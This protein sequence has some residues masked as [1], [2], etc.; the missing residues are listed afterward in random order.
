MINACII[1][2]ISF[3][4]IVDITFQADKKAMIAILLNDIDL[5]NVFF[6]Y[7]NCRNT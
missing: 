7:E 2:Y 1:C 3:I 6:W 5:P 4:K